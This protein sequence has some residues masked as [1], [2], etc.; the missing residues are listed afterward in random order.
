[1]HHNCTERRQK[2]TLPLL[3]LN[4]NVSLRAEEIPWYNS[5]RSLWHS[6][7]LLLAF[8]DQSP[9][10]NLLLQWAVCKIHTEYYLQKLF[11]IYPISAKTWREEEYLQ[12]FTIDERSQRNKN[13]C[14]RRRPWTHKTTSWTRESVMRSVF[15]VPIP[16]IFRSLFYCLRL[17][18]RGL[19]LFQ[20][21]RAKQTGNASFSSLFFWETC[22]RHHCSFWRQNPTWRIDYQWKSEEKCMKFDAF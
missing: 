9:L 6:I 19:P 8:P 22:P 5:F 2:K 18:L 10:S 17:L 13:R 14:F 1:M 11:T 7:L 4:E 3:S 20:F 15:C 21:T 12:K 16:L